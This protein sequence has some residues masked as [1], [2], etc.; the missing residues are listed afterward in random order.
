M[1]TKWKKGEFNVEM[2]GGM[3]VR[4]GYVS[5]LWGIRKM[6]WGE[7]S[8]THR[9]S[10]RLVGYLDARSLDGVK[11]NIERTAHFQW[12]APTID[13]VCRLNGMTPRALAEAVI[14]A[15]KD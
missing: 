13:E 3:E 1:A 14:A 7:W 12:G 8:A 15:I 9:P 10:G 6:P 5:D 11:K 4:K 2:P